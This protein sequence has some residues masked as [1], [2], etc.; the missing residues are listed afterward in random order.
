[1]R[2]IAIIAGEESGDARGSALMREMLA[3]D[4]TIQF[5]GVGGPR[6]AVLATGKFEDWIEQAGVVGLWDVLRHYSWFRQKFQELRTLI[7]KALPDAVIFVDYPGFNLRMAAALRADLPKVKLLYYISPQVWAWNRRRI[8]KMARILDLMVCI[9]PF[10]KVLYEKSGLRTEFSGHP[11]VEEL[12][13]EKKTTLVRDAT[14]VGLFPGSRER[15]IHRLFP[16]LLEAAKRIQLSRPDVHF[17]VAA[18]RK[19]QAEWMQ[20]VAEKAGVEC[21]IEVGAAHSLMQRA[22]VGLVCSGTA[23]L[24]AALFGLPYALVYRVAWLTYQIGRHL[25]TIRFLGMI[26]I[27]ADRPIVREFIQ[28]DCNAFALADEVLRLLNSEDARQSLTEELLT[29]TQCLGGTGAAQRAATAVMEL[30]SSQS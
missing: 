3:I 22:G 14:L 23:S 19:N 26:N 4:P 10:E 11:L 6:M 2:R 9:F 24:E 29:A 8:P 28:H 16:V 27:L 5:L 12:S 1:M 25:V 7:G 30:V 17:S 13:L 15:E 18:A 21:E 20:T